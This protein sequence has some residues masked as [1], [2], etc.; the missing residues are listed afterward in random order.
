MQDSTFIYFDFVLTVARL[1]NVI[2]AMLKHEGITVPGITT[3]Q[4]LYLVY[5]CDREDVD[6]IDDKVIDAKRFYY[7]ISRLE[8]KGLLQIQTKGKSIQAFEATPKGQQVIDTITQILT[9]QFRQL[10]LRGLR[11]NDLSHILTLIYRFE[12]FWTSKA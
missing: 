4:A 10:T 3:S 7:T 6:L 11:V 12:R 8:S 2:E 1:H 9:V 5:L